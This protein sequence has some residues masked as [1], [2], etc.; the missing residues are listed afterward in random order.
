MRPATTKLF[1]K[2]NSANKMTM[3]PADLK[4]KPAYRLF[5][6]LNELKLTKPRMGSVP[7]ANEPIVRAPLRKLPVERVYICIDCVKP[8]GKKNVAMPTRK[9]VSVWLSFV[10][11][12][13][14]LAKNFGIEG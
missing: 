5:L 7:N 13:A 11:P 14:C 12:S 10:A 6:M 8:Q 1:I 9:G 2:L 4:K 3:S